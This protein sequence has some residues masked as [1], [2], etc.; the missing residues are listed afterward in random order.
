MAGCAKN[1]SET[2]NNIDSSRYQELSISLTNGNAVTAYTSAVFDVSCN[3][4]FPDGSA[5]SQSGVILNSSNPNLIIINKVNCFITLKSY[6]NSDGTYIPIKSNSKLVLSLDTNGNSTTPPTSIE[7]FIQSSL[8]SFYFAAVSYTYNAT[9]NFAIDPTV[10]QNITP[11]QV[12]TTPLSFNFEQIIAPTVTSS[13][14]ITKTVAI[15]GF[16]VSYTLTGAV[17]GF[18]DCKMFDQ[19]IYKVPTKW[20]WTE[21]YNLFNNGLNLSGVFN[22]PPFGVQGNWDAYGQKNM[23]IIWRNQPTGNNGSSALGAFTV[24][25]TSADKL[26]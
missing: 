14:A 20:T 18:T 23:I 3:K 12:T 22:C 16:P 6:T 25:T 7:Y 2:S 26:P 15:N 9:F 17:N 1:S 13:L 24:T 5:W 4:V 19:S 8:P 10:A 11:K 21:A